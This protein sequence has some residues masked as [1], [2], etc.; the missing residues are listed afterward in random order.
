MQYDTV[1]LGYPGHGGEYEVQVGFG[2]SNGVV[3][4]FINTYGD[5]LDSFDRESS[6]AH[7]VSHN[8]DTWNVV[9][10]L[11]TFYVFLATRVTY[12]QSGDCKH[13]FA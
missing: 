8:M 10:L 4:D 13:V 11:V 2:W 12:H 9:F 6:T 3:L 1:S 7:R 5:R